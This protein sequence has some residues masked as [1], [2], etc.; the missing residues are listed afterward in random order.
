MGLCLMFV[1]NAP[2]LGNL[3]TNELVKANRITM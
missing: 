3:E 1:A 2:V